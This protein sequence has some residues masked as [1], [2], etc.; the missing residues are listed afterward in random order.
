MNKKEITYFHF[1]EESNCFEE[2]SDSEDEKL[3]EDW[4]YDK[5]INTGLY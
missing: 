5:D 1:L 3:G 4:M 2:K